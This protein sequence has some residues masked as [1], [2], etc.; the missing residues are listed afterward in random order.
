MP[1]IQTRGAARSRQVGVLLPLPFDE[2]FTYRVPDDVDAE[3][4]D[5]VDVPF[6]PRRVAGVVWNEGDGDVPPEK[7]KDVVGV[8]EVPGL[9]PELR[10]FVEW[11]AAYTMSNAGSVLKMVLSV[12]DGLL[13]PKPVTAYALADGVP[14]IRMTDARKRVIEAAGGLPPLP[15]ADLAREAGCGPSVVKGLAEAG[16]LEQ[17]TLVPS[18]GFQP[19]DLSAEGPALSPEQAA[20]AGALREL[21][22][23]HRFGVSVLEGI[24]GAGKTEVYLEAVVAALEAGKQA[25]VLLPEIALSAQWMDRF[26]RRFGCRPAEWHSD[27]TPAQRRINWRAVATGE[28]RVVVGARSALFLPYPEL[29]LI[30]VDEEQDASYKQEDGV[31]YNARDMAIV[32]AR[33]EEVPVV[34]VSATPSLETV[35]NVRQGRYGHH[36]LPDRHAGAEFPDVEVVDMRADSPPAGEWLSSPLRSAVTE[37]LDQGEQALLFLNRRGYAP[38]TLCRA[39]GHR[40]Q[41]PNCTSWL[42]EHRLMNR[43]QCHH[44]G[45]AADLPN[46]CPSCEAEN[47][48]AACGPGVERLAEEVAALY[49]DARV[50][51]AAS[52]TI[53]GPGQAAELV[54]LIEDRDVDIVIGTQIVAKGYHFPHLTLVGVVDSDL[55]LSGGDLRAAERTYQLL[56][57]VAGR[58]G[59]EH[60]PG[61][62]VLQTFM[63][64][65]PVIKSLAAGDREGFLSAEA[66]DREIAGMPPFGRLAGVVLSSPDPYQVDRAANA[67]RRTAPSEDGVQVLG[68]APAPMALLRGRHRRR[69]LV[70]TSRDVNLQKALRNWLSAT[71]IPKKVRV[72]LDIDPYSFM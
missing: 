38:L 23:A 48:L 5:I 43:L 40:L 11:V 52:D 31:I 72:Q 8:F 26:R 39:C 49:P 55:G 12:P 18:A 63:P 10:R 68:P 24:P 14:D 4:G 41:C 53:H 33:E 46:A 64:D 19:P 62:V 6:G 29:G 60:R 21:A 28:A 16:V 37:T 27:L 47:R 61:R 9:R 51:V 54:R 3:L 56:Y 44:C 71:P 34:L 22:A 32:R 17:R 65:H 45:Y 58:A 30:V 7:L 69:F 36:N 15:A 59:R 57:Q 70:K 1:P 13:P 50:V 35:E 66:R 2:P 67:L 25:L 20:A 42:V